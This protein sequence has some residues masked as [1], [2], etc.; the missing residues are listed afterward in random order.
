M[1]VADDNG[2]QDWAADYDGEGQ[3][4]AVRDGGDRGVVMMAVAKMVAAEVSGSGQQW[5]WRQT[6]A[7]DHD[8]MQDWAAAYNGEGQEWA[9]NNDGISY[10]NIQHSSSKKSAL[11]SKSGA[12]SAPETQFLAY[13]FLFFCSAR[14]TM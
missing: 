3:E 8:I 11:L 6:T 13:C 9:A 2:L 5:Q 1:T 10:K 7:A 14:E 4:R 12:R